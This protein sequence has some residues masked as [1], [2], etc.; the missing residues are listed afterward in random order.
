MGKGRGVQ[1]ESRWRTNTLHH[2][3]VE[4]ELKTLWRFFTEIQ[5]GSPIRFGD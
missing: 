3:T 1:D 2:G 5:V 4:C